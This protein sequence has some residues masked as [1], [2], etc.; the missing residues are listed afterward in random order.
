MA[1]P[2]HSSRISS[3]FLSPLSVL[4]CGMC[5]V[6]TILI[7]VSLVVQIFTICLD[8]R[9]AVCS[10]LTGWQ[11]FMMMDSLFPFDLALPC[12]IMMLSI[13]SLFFA[14]TRVG[15]I[16]WI[17][18]GFALSVWIGSLLFIHGIWVFA[19]LLVLTIGSLLQIGEWLRLRHT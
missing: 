17:Q 18:G 19:G 16:V 4:G 2:A 13:G 14:Q 15:W 3:F 7:M 8:G 6:G 1:M 10:M 9:I 11:Y 5:L 12:V